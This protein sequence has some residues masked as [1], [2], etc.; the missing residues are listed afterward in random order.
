MPMSKTNLLLIKKIVHNI[1]SAREIKLI[2]GNAQALR[3]MCTVLANQSDELQTAAPYNM[4]A[5]NLKVTLTDARD[6]AVRAQDYI[7]EQKDPGEKGAPLNI[8]KLI[9]GQLQGAGSFLKK[10]LGEAQK[11]N[12]RANDFEIGK[13]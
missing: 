12:E 13:E 9:E 8:E 4:M 11:L 3:E 2:P 6:C 7:R 5:L 1:T 10:A